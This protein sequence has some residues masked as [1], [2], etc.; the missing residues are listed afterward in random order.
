MGRRC[1][2]DDNF[3][4]SFTS[5]SPAGVEVTPCA[6]RPR[7]CGGT[8]NPLGMEAFVPSSYSFPSMHTYVES[9]R[10]GA[11]ISFAAVDLGSSSPTVRLSIMLL[12]KSYR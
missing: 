1:S 5:S 9:A 7:L 11:V 6:E 2:S 3:I 8:G 10:R 4:D 12:A